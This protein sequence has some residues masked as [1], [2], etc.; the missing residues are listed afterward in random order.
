M[1]KTKHQQNRVPKPKQRLKASSLCSNTLLREM[2]ASCK[3]E[4]DFQLQGKK[5]HPEK[6]EFNKA[7]GAFFIALLVKIFEYINE[8]YLTD[9][10]FINGIISFLLLE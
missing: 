8:S 1:R 7:T 5:N 10:L 4:D 6:Q 2:T 3:T 9:G